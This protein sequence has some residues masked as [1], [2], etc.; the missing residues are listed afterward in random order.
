MATP[1]PVR[2]HCDTCGHDFPPTV[3]V[4]PTCRAILIVPEGRKK[5]PGW[6]IGLLVVLI[7][8]LAVYAAVLAYQVLVLHKYS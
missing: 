2:H 5:T 3:Y 6:V 1:A 7:A 8:L 4:C